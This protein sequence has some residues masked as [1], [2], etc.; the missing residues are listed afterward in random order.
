MA[1]AQHKQVVNLPL[2]ALQDCILDFDS[3]PQFAGGVK[4]CKVL[5]KEGNSIDV[6]M[7]VEIMKKNIVYSISVECDLKAEKSRI[8]WKLKEGDFFQQNDGLWELTA[9]GPNTTSVFVST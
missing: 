9:M 5:K 4:T 8:W 2:K 3:Y 1:L 6:A 7:A